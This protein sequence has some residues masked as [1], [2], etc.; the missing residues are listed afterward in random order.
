MQVI[1]IINKMSTARMEYQSTNGSVLN[2]FV[3]PYFIER[4]DLR[5]ISHSL[6]LVGS[7]GSGKSTYIKYFSHAT[8]FDKKISNLQKNELNCIILYWKP[9]ITY[10]QGLKTN[11]LGDNALLF[12]TLHSSLSILEELARFIDNASFHFKDFS[13]L[14]EKN[15]NFWERVSNVTCE[16]IKTTESLLKWI[17]HYEYKISTRLNPLNTDD[18]ITILPDSMLKYLTDGLREDYE[19]L[20]DSVFKIF[21][22]EFELITIEQQKVINNYRKQ[23]SA[24]LN[25]NVAYKANAK[26]TKETNSSQWLQSPDDF[27]EVDIDELMKNDYKIF[28]AEIFILTLQNAGLKCSIDEL[29]PTYLGSRDNINHRKKDSYKRNVLNIVNNILP[30]PTVKELSEICFDNKS[31]KTIIKSIYK[32]F[33]FDKYLVDKVNNDPS[34]AITLIGIHKQNSFDIEVWKSYLRETASLEIVRAIKDKIYTFEF[35]T[36]LSLNLQ[37]TSI[38]TPVYAGFDRFITM[39]TP[40][41]RHFKEICLNALRYSQDVDTEVNYTFIDDI[42]SITLSGMHQ[43]AIVT[44]SNL[45]KEVSSYP[46]YGN[47]LTRLVNRMGELFKISQKTSYQTEP[48]RVIFTI[49]YDFAGSD[50]KLESFLGSALSWRVLNA[51]DSRRIKDDYQITSKEFQLNPIYSPRFGISYRKKRGITLTLS[52]FKIIISGSSEEF[53]NIKKNYQRKWKLED[54][55]EVQGILFND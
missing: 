11:W 16:D 20:K 45:V 46:P 21:V 29:S 31:V 23:S 26:P 10:C 43:G 18:L 17:R 8:R 35:N 5:N 32:E 42:R 27:R 33:S 13:Q 24:N 36:L 34:L 54:I 55:S 41:I 39:S 15:N 52:E 6:A 1:D 47:Q 30:M 48:E 53:E 19:P 3:V 7:R 50:E 28:A 40:N 9:D 44:S 2:K 38:E 51:D 12:F 4:L 22:D 25:W 14:L 37:H 49:P